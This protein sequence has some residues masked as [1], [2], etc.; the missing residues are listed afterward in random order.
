VDLAVF[1]QTGLVP[2]GDGFVEIRSKAGEV[3]LLRRPGFMVVHATPGGLGE[4]QRTDPVLLGRATSRVAG[5]GLA[6]SP[7]P[8]GL[9]TAPSPVELYTVLEGPERP[10]V[11]FEP[12]AVSDLCD[13]ETV[14][15]NPAFTPF[16]P[17]GSGVTWPFP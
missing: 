15:L 8:R 10:G 4:P 16:L 14:I 6:S 11:T 1:F 12:C 2:G 9:E 3:A 7:L 5:I 13:A 17:S